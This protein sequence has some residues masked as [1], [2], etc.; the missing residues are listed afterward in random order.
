[1]ERPPGAMGAAK[2]SIASATA[3][4]FNES[5]SI[6]LVKS[7]FRRL[8]PRGGNAFSSRGNLW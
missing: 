1:M 7:P 4:S 6:A 5:L 8:R 2:S 3:S